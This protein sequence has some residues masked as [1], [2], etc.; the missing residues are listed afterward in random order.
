MDNKDSYDSRRVDERFIRLN[1]EFNKQTNNVAGIKTKSV[2]VT[3][4]QQAVYLE[5]KQ[6]QTMSFIF[7]PINTISLQKVKQHYHKVMKPYDCMNGLLV[8]IYQFHFSLVVP[9]GHC[10]ESK[11]YLNLRCNSS[12]HYVFLIVLFG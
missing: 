12:T 4:N 2:I 1:N 9:H 6:I 11:A 5:K 7:F 10:I 8:H 3:L